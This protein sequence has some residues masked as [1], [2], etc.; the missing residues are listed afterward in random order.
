M[1]VDLD[2][3]TLVINPEQAAALAGLLVDGKL[4]GTVFED[5]EPPRRVALVA[6][7]D[8]VEAIDPENDVA[9]HTLGVVADDGRV[10]QITAMGICWPTPRP[11]PMP[12]EVT[13]T[14]PAVRWS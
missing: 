14:L 1:D 8:L 6:A 13:I 10:W 7:G 2:R 5:V 11:D 9:V 3:A 4:Y 12:A